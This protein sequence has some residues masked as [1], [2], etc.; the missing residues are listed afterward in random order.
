MN[1]RLPSFSHL[2]VPFK[3]S[4][5][6]WLP[7]ATAPGYH[8]KSAARLRPD[9][10]GGYKICFRVTYIKIKG[11]SLK[12][13]LLALLPGACLNTFFF[14]SHNRPLWSAGLP[15]GRHRFK[16][17]V[18][19]DWLDYPSQ[20][21]PGNKSSVFFLGPHEVNSYCTVSPRGKHLLPSIKS[22]SSLWITDAMMAQKNHFS[23]VS[24]VVGVCYLF[25][26]GD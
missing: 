2:S 15:S 4:D 7:P 13:F 6:L 11:P 3:V 5:C 18:C 20:G 9:L 17:T 23:G 10:R 1:N 22:T 25:P 14:S 19:Y 24:V 21:L 26:W 16:G 8:T 12:C